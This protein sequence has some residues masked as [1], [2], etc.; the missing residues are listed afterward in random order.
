MKAV[1]LDRDGVLNSLIPRGDSSLR[2]PWSLAEL[3]LEPSSRTVTDALASAGWSLFVVTNQPDVVRGHIPR[4]EAVLINSVLKSNLPSVKQIYTCFHDNLDCC[5]CRKPKP[6][7]IFQAATEHGV[8]L[9]NSFVV[10]DRWVDIAAG[11]AAGCKT[12]LLEKPYSWRATS[13]GSAPRGCIPYQ[14]LDSLDAVC[15]KIL[16]DGM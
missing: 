7:L 6:G 1:F 9:E 5:A 15:S 14:S 10:G 13:L 8:Q 12:L 11:Q 3:K 4:G 2:A 16:A